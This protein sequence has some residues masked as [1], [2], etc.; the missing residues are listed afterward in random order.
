MWGNEKAVVQPLSRAYLFATLWT[1]AH[2]ASLSFTISWRLMSI[3]DCSLSFIQFD[4]SH[5]MLCKEV[6]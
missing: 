4:V 5:D 2:Q 3:L 1:A 6:K